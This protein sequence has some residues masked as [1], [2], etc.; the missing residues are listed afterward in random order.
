M[1][2]IKKNETLNSF[3][4][5]Q[6][7]FLAIFTERPSWTEYF[8]VLAKIAATRATCLSRPTGAVIVRD[9][10][11]LSTGYCG[12][13]PGVDHCSDDGFCFKR[14][15]GIS[16]A[17]KYDGC[18]SVHAEANAIAQAA[19]RGISIEGAEIFVTLYPCYV[20][21]KLLVQAGI[22]KVYYEYE[23][24]SE[25]SKRD[26]LWEEALELADICIE[27]VEIS[28]ITIKKTLFSLLGATSWRREL[29]PTGEPTGRIENINME[30]VFK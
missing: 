7:D 12:S 10:Q 1:K 23:Y 17:D 2:K 3:A 24:K 14:N 6:E 19:K 29:K 30:E 15:S 22:K 4:K 8:M 27:K 18:R 16:G 9:K 26:K 5:T 11:V 25:N 20:C 21:T 13:M 28:D